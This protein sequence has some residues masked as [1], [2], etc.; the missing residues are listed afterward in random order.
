MM[1]IAG[2]QRAARSVDRRGAQ[3][4]YPWRGRITCDPAPGSAG[5]ARRHAPAAADA[6]RAHSSASAIPTHWGYRRMVL[7][8]A[9][10]AADAGGVDAFLIGSELRGLTRVRSASGVYPAVDA[11]VDARRRREGDR[12]APAR[13]S[14]MAPTG[15]NTARM[16]SMPTPTRCAFR[17]IR[18][19]RRPRSTRSASTTTRRCPTG[20]TAP[21]HLDR[22]R[23]SA[24]Y[25]RAYLGGN[26]RGGEAYDWYYADDAARAAQTRTPITD[27]ARQAVGVPQQ[28]HLEL[29]EQAALRARRRRRSSA[30]RPRGCRRASRSGSPRSAARP[31]TRAPTSRACSPI[32][33]RRRIALAAISRTASATI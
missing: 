11:L 24:I 29:V 19:G 1:D 17:S 12:S 30:R 27:G 20:A 23:A 5:L 26:L 6:G 18:C 15:P 2:R 25:D 4:A 28:G 13:S 16:S 31:S 14:P 22:A 21:T 33:N 8:Y 32:R 7:H 10:L 9:Q 3:P